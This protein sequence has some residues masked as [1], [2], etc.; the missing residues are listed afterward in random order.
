MNIIIEFRDLISNLKLQRYIDY[1]YILIIQLIT[2]L[3]E[4]FIIR[5]ACLDNQIMILFLMI[6]MHNVQLLVNFLCV[7]KLYF[8]SCNSIQSQIIDSSFATK[9][10]IQSWFC[11]LRFTFVWIQIRKQDYRL[12]WYY[13]F[14]ILYYVLHSINNEVGYE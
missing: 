12:K 6:P 5:V 2:L 14:S 4:E 3:Y 13:L 1:E 9:K 10:L 7:S 8:Y 11:Y